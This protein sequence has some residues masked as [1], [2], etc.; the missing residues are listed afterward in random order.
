[1]RP[2]MSLCRRRQC[3][4]PDKTPDITPDI[5]DDDAPDNA[6]HAADDAAD[7]A[8]EHVADD[9]AEHVAVNTDD[10]PQKYRAW[11]GSDAVARKARAKAVL[12]VMP[13][14]KGKTHRAQ[15]HS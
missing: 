14:A 15:E 4:P 9:A 5:T 12:T 1:M 10:A 2:A 13:K 11:Q 3:R 6:D 7:D 8:A